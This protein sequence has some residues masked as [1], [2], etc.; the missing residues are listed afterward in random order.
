MNPNDKIPVTLEASV[1]NQVLMLLAEGPFRVA[2]P[3]IQS[4]QAQ[5]N[6]WE[7][8]RAPRGGDSNVIPMNE[9]GE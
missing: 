1:W 5:C 9:A 4:I 2:S 8:N 6:E 3:L 7:A